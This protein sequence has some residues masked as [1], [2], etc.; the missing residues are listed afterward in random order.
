MRLSR[1]SSLLITI[2]AACCL[3]G[4]LATT[5]VQLENCIKDI[6][7]K[8]LTSVGRNYLLIFGTFVFFI[9]LEC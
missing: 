1:L 2:A 7:S 8:F 9:A 5:S 6:G 3:Q 4:L